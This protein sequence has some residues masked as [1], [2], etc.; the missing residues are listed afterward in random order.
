MTQ[1]TPYGVPGLCRPL[2]G[3]EHDRGPTRRPKPA[4]RSILVLN[5]SFGRYLIPSKVFPHANLTPA[6]R[7]Y[8]HGATLE[9]RAEL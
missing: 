8:V 6:R 9:R 7:S 2:A 4:Y 5:L 1:D 3:G